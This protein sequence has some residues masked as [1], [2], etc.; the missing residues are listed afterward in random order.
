MEGETDFL[1]TEA[2]E[3]GGEQPVCKALGRVE[4][5]PNPN[6]LVTYVKLRP[7]FAIRGYTTASMMGTMITIK[8]AFTVC[9]WSG[10]E[11][12]LLSQGL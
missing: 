11:L 4:L 8:M 5:H 7:H 1:S 6:P 12:L 2:P 9:R 3:A 10:D